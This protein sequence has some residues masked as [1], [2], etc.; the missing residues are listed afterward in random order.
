MIKVDGA[1]TQALKGLREFAKAELLLPGDERGTARPF[2]QS[3]ESRSVKT[4]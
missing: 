1:G 4:T 2:S 3:A